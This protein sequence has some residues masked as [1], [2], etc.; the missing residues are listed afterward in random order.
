MLTEGQLNKMIQDNKDMIYISFIGEVLKEIPDGKLTSNKAIQKQVQNIAKKEGLTAKEFL[1]K[2]TKLYKQ[3]EKDIIKEQAEPIF[4][5]IYCQCCNLR[6]G[7]C[8]IPL[9][10]QDI[11]KCLIEPGQEFNAALDKL[12]GLTNNHLSIILSNLDLESI[13]L[14]KYL[15]IWLEQVINFEKEGD[16]DERY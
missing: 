5:Y 9:S 11:R 7:Y 8:N 12:E 10:F 3:K 4:D 16:I 14:N 2:Y 15:E 6:N 13:L 1:D